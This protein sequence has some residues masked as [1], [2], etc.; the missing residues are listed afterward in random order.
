MYSKLFKTFFF[1]ESHVQILNPQEHFSTCSL[2]LYGKSLTSS[3][4][5]F[6]KMDWRIH[7][8]IKELFV[9]LKILFSFTEYILNVIFK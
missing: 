4:T 8:K 7:K 6:T 5:L 2:Y 9:F 1:V 3:E